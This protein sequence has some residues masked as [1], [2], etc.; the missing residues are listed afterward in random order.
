MALGLDA[1]TPSFLHQERRLSAQLKLHLSAPSQNLRY[2][3]PS[4]YIVTFCV[5]AV[6]VAWSIFQRCAPTQET[7]LLALLFSRLP[8]S[9]PTRVCSMSRRQRRSN[10]Q[11]GNLLYPF[12]GTRQC[13]AW[14][15]N[16]L[17]RV[18]PDL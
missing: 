12:C 2:D 11:G 1:L 18:T 5:Y 9:R 4:A 3:L 15:I 13:R 8:H 16:R 10:H 6:I 17:S 7:W 14:L